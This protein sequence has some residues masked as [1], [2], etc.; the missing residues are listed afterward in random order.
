MKWIVY[1]TIN[2]KN[3]KIYIGVH[4]T[5]DPY[6]FDSYLGC[7]CLATNPSTYMNPTTPFQYAVKKY[8]PSAFKRSV[9]YICDT[10]EEAF[11]KEKDIVTIDFVKRKDT[12]NA[13]TGGLNSIGLNPIN[14]F[15]LKGNLIKTW[16]RV[17][18]A[19]EFYGVHSNSIYNASK[20]KTSCNKY[21][22]SKEFKINIHDYSI[23]VGKK[24]Y[25]YNGETGKYLDTY[26]TLSSA[27]KINNE[28]LMV[29]E[30]AVKGGYKVKGFYYSTELFDEYKGKPKL[31]IKKI[32]IYLYDLEG[33]YVKT[34]N[35]GKEIC[36]Y[37][38]IKSV[39][40]ITTAIRTEREYKG[41]QISL[42]KKEKLPPI[43]SKRNNPKSVGRYT[44]TGDLLEIYPSASAAIKIYGSG[45][46]R[47]LKGQQNHCHNFIFRWIKS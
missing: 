5:V 2:V 32:P 25:K 11:E 15:D 38:G 44:M 31:S 27:A 21:F 3:N 36:D 18:E 26:E 17:I 45:V 47:V 1:H 34:L 4:K 10:A 19:A 29:I 41:Y 16:D 20:F 46:T 22:W 43:K 40:R 13:C 42:D 6:I 37:F 14:Q 9:L 35:N 7:G 30:R 39:G 33:N 24:C 12:Y 28:R 8:G 23:N